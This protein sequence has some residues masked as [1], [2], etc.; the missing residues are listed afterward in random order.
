[1]KLN[2]DTSAHEIQQM[3]GPAATT[4]EARSML[5]MMI[6]DGY[7]DTDQLTVDQWQDLCHAAFSNPEADIR[8]TPIGTVEQGIDGRD[9]YV[10]ITSMDDALDV[11]FAREW[12][13]PQVYRESM[14][15][16]GYFCTSVT[17]MSHPLA[18]NRCVAIIHHR[19]DV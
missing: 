11:D 2:H 4:A 13:L 14:R 6:S 9:E 16:G 8:I 10:L 5:R 3:M 12:L 17:I 18:T 1:M 7:T 19:Y 15:P